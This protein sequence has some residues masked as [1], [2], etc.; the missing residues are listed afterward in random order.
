MSGWSAIFG[1]IF[2]NRKGC[3]SGM[4]QSVKKTAHFRSLCGAHYVD[5]DHGYAWYLNEI[6]TPRDT[7]I[8][9]GVEFEYVSTSI[10]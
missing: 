10:K 5:F 2:S 6:K 7:I 9:R 1:A 4:T 8:H 3:G